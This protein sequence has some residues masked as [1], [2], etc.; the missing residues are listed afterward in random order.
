[1]PLHKA[2]FVTGEDKLRRAVSRNKP[3]PF[4]RSARREPRVGRHAGPT[5]TCMAPTGLEAPIEP[6]VGS[7]PGWELSPV[8]RRLPCDGSTFRWV[9]L[10]RSWGVMV[11]V[12]LSQ[13]LR[14]QPLRMAV[15]G[16]SLSA[17]Y[18]SIRG[19]AGV[20]DPTEYAAITVPGWESMSWVEV[21]GRLRS[22]AVNLGGYDTKLLGWGP[23]R[24]SGYE[25]NFAIPGFEA[26]QFEQVVN[27]SIFSDP[28]YLLY[29]RQITGVLQSQADAAVVWLG[30]NEFRAN[31][32]FL[33]DGGDPV[34]LV[35]SLSND[36]AEVLD[37]V[38]A[39]KTGIKLVVVNLPD[40]GATPDKQAAHPDA[41]K[42]ANV[43][44]ATV[45]ANQAIANLAATRGIAVADA[46]SETRN[47]VNDE[48]I[49][50]GPVNIFA[51]SHP[52][53]HPRHAFTRDGLHPNACLQARIANLVLTAFN[54]F[55]ST[56]IPLLTDG[57][58]LGLIGVDPMQPY[59]DWVDDE[60]LVKSGLGD[61]PDDDRWVNLAEF[62]FDLDP[63]VQSPSPLKVDTGSSPVAIRYH[64]HP[65]RLRLVAVKPQWSMHLSHWEDVPARSLN[66]TP[67]GQ[68]TISLPP[69]ETL[70]FVRVQL[71]VRPVQ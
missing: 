27:S 69:G 5:M 43:T 53:N 16:D 20:D 17:E 64:V 28:Q 38:L 34:P 10:A 51:G 9:N 50:I 58:I 63:G 6:H 62:V 31:Y 55:Y 8:N 54:Q 19:I 44:A 42:R 15:L 35:N 37:F 61:D 45:L 66:S 41:A 12:L 65:D 24:F 3:N 67:D 32:G 48:T 46:F 18:E 29:K 49:W 4:L 14:A 71:S 60:S 11:C 25:C 59:L 68:T 36:L 22:D 1:M 57:E 52:D 56:S 40:L 21:L 33:Y 13:T 26:S 70:R 2:C 30:G 23:L 47:L 7:Q 39:Q